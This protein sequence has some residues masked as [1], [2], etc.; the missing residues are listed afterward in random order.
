MK[1]DVEW[2]APLQYGGAAWLAAARSVLLSIWCHC[3]GRR[4]QSSCFTSTCS[5]R[6]MSQKKQSICSMGIFWPVLVEKLLEPS[7]FLLLPC[8]F[9][10]SWIPE[11]LG[12]LSPPE[13]YPCES[14][15]AVKHQ[16]SCKS[17]GRKVIIT[18]QRT[19][20]MRTGICLYIAFGI[21]N[22]GAQKNQCLWVPRWPSNSPVLP[23]PSWVTYVQPK[24]QHA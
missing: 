7:F 24:D 17:S 23:D 2:V 1:W 10:P 13:L 3:D 18:E 6:R 22:S 4:Q 8:S 20:I 11:D 12:W 19:I 5:C 14:N 9:T 21:T 16:G 15:H